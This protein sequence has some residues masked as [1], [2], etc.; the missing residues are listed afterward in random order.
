MLLNAEGLPIE[1][2]DKITVTLNPLASCFITT[3]RPYTDNMHYIRLDQV[4]YYGKWAFLTIQSQRIDHTLDIRCSIAKAIY[5][6]I[7]KKILVFPIDI[8]LIFI[9][10][11]L[12]Y[13]VYNIKEIEFY[14]DFIEG[15][16]HILQPELLNQIGTSYYS[17]DYRSSKNSHTRKS[18]LEVYDHAGNLVRLNQTSR[19]KLKENPYTKR[20]EFNLTKYNSPNMT[21]SDLSGNYDEVIIRYTHYL[22][23]LYSR[24]FYGNVIVND[25][26]HYHFN[27]IYQLAA[28]G[29]KRYT[30]N[31]L[32]K[33]SKKE[34]NPEIEKFWNKKVFLHYENTQKESNNSAKLVEK[35]LKN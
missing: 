26:E 21:L 14:F 18:L 6:L 13:F 19:K 11:K 27:K 17:S 9:Y 7:E 35:A 2:I 20:I 3:E 29:R 30:G 15:N 12:D 8:P 31:E 10:M 34:N 25:F 16:I 28:K 5:E 33:V 22:A 1:G 23:V 24:Y 32:E 4:F